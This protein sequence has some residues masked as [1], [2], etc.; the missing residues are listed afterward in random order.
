MTGKGKFIEVQGTA[1][2]KPF[3]ATQLEAMT[4]LA[5]EG[6]ATLVGLQKKVLAESTGG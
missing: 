6:I 1:E 5:T 4:A 3:T 2:G